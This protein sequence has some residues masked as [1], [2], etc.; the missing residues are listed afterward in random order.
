MN[1]NNKNKKLIEALKEKNFSSNSQDNN[2]YNSNQRNNML[3]NLVR[4]ISITIVLAII[5]LI[6]SFFV[7]GKKSYNEIE[8]I[9]KK[10]AISYYEQNPTLLPKNT[11]ATV[12]VSATKLSN[13]KYMRD[14][15]KYIK[16]GSCT[17]K[18]VVEN[19]DDNYIYIPYLDCGTAY[20]T[21]ELFRKITTANNIVE[22]GI[23]LYSIGSEYIYRGEVTNNYVSINNYLYR[24][25]KVDE[26][27]EVVLIKEE[28]KKLSSIAWD[29]RYN[30]EKG[31]TTGINDFNVSRIKAELEAIYDDT[32]KNALFT[33]DDRQ[34]LTY[35]NYCIDKVD[36]TDE[37]ST[38]C[39]SSSLK[40]K[41]GL[42]TASE[43]I[44]A[45]ID[46]NCTS[47]GS[48]SCQNYNYLVK[49]NIDW[50]LITANSENTYESYYV[51]GRG[52]IDVANC[53]S[54]NRIRPVIYL[55]SKTMY[56][57]GTGTASDPYLLM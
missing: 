15:N 25:V 35:H 51:T 3:K 40:L 22:S 9:M 52:L 39:N 23:G 6:L 44:N 29:N 54:I 17:G 4:I 32:S 7:T 33:D 8:S 49:K 12:E 41:V 31:R 34:Y 30:I 47:F 55:N 24:I 26:N 28:E 14:V 50:W 13:L 46:E 37:K 2:S 45:S 27:N 18:V 16:K 10:A 1:P 53:S 43:Y 21:T 20:K 36:I 48:K 56:K 57:S 42:L 5:L 38:S 19:N 11:G